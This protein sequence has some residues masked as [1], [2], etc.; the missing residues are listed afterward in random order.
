M[1]IIKLKYYLTLIMLYLINKTYKKELLMT[2]V[3]YEEIKLSNDS[4]NSII[5]CEELSQTQKR[6]ELDKKRKLLMQKV[7]AKKAKQGYSSAY[8]Q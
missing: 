2:S 6:L 8:Q 5:K 3:F 7:L 4:L 1:R